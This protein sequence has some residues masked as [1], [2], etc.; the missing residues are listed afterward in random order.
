M[1]SRAMSTALETRRLPRPSR[2]RHV[3]P[4]ALLL[5]TVLLWSFN[6]TTTRYGITHRVHPLVY[7]S[8]RWMTA[9][10]ALG[11]LATLRGH[12]LWIGRRD[13]A[14][15]TLATIAGVVLNQIAFSYSLHLVTASTV[16]L[17]FGTLPTFVS[18]MS[19]LAG[20][21]RLHA[22]H[23]LA[24]AVSFAGVALVAAGSGSGIGVNAVGILL[25]LATTFSFAV[26]SVGIVPSMQRHSPLQVNATS[27]IIGG[28]LLGLIAIPWLVAEPWSAPPPLAWGSLL[29]SSLGSVVVGNL[30]WFTAIDRAGAGR[31]ALYANLQ[32]FLGAVFAVLALSEH[33]HTLQLVGGVVIASGI[34]LGGRRS[35]VARRAR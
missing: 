28:L 17:V 22:R 13:T 30:F 12:S 15:V 3:P 25:A 7:A 8:L 19:H 1:I 27:C 2:P 24:T 14:R 23:W 33:L 11:L 34:V 4:E 18:L 5:G 9:G 31:S 32:P 10:A 16:A 21:E 20:H 26:Y 6:F 29:Y 35:L